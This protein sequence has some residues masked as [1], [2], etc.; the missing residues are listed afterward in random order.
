MNKYTIDGYTRISKARARKMFNNSETVYFCACNLK[1]G[2]PWYPEAAIKKEYTFNT[3][4]NA[5][6][7]FEFYNCVNSETGKYAAFYTREE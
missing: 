6:N 7:C 5:V 2:Y 4:E 3:F 1:P